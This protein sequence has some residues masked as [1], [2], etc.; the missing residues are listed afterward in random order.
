MLGG[1]AD[2]RRPAALTF[3]KGGCGQKLAE[4]EDTGER[5]TDVV[6]QLCQHQLGRV[7]AGCVPAPLR[8]G[9]VLARSWRARARAPALRRRSALGRHGGPRSTHLATRRLRGPAGLTAGNG[10]CCLSLTVAEA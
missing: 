2:R 8:A 7:R 9:G 3:A 4:R 10:P 6:G 1:A 5:R